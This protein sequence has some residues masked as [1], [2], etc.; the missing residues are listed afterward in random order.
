MSAPLRL[1]LG[2]LEAM[3]RDDWSGEKIGKKEE[4]SRKL[5]AMH[6]VAE[7][8]RFLADN[9]NADAM[10]IE[11]KVI[12]VINA[13]MPYRKQQRGRRE[14]VSMPWTL[15][16]DQKVRS[17]LAEGKSLR[18]AVKSLPEHQQGAAKAR[19]Q[20]SRRR[21]RDQDTGDI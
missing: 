4:A 18:K 16:I 15:P 8:W 20:R 2:F 7:G 11:N 19:I 3:I 21:R 5:Q 13:L 1:G 9:E 10:E 6:V 12:G 14:G 17:S